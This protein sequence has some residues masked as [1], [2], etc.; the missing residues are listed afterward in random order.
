MYIYITN[1]KNC[2]I[3]MVCIVVLGL[4]KFVEPFTNRNG[5]VVVGGPS[6][7]SIETLQSY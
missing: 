4:D 2:K 5:F 6:A 1:S 7:F 3:P